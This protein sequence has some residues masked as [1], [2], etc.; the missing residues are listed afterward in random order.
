MAWPSLRMFSVESMT[1]ATSDRRTGE[2]LRQATISGAIFGG[3]ARL[4]VGIELVAPLADLE[5]AL[6]RIGIGG[7][8]RGAHAFQADA[9]FRQARRI[10]LDPHRRQRTAAQ[11]HLADAGHLAQAL[12]Q[13]VGRGVV[14]AALAQRVRGE[15]QHQDRRIGGIDLAILRVGRQIARHVHARG[16][17]GG[18]HVARR[19]VDAARQVEL[20]R[21]ARI[22]DRARRGHLGD[23]GD[24][25]ER[26]FE[27][28]REAGGDRFRR[29]AR[30]AGRDLDGR[31]VD[32]GQ[33]RRPAA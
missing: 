6:G 11:G 12:L 27:R 32:L 22:A 24:R 15:G 26:P 8:Q 20:Q 30:Q 29:G 3:G 5:G 7:R 9:V 21:D 4:V 19:P 28:R 23:A 1:S 2:P 16:I 18:L 10:D 17:D 31:K 14:E 33:R 13:D 25:A